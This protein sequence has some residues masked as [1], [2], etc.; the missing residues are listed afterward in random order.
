MTGT[1]YK[2]AKGA[3]VHQ[4]NFIHT[5]A[6]FPALVAGFG[7]GK[8]EGGIMRTLHKKFEHRTMNVGY[9]L[10]TYDL[11]KEI[12]IPRFEEY[13]TASGTPFKINY[14]D[15]VIKIEKAGKI[16][17]RTMMHPERIIGYEHAHAVV[18][19]LDTLQIDKARDVWL[20]ILGRNRQQPKTGKKIKNTCGVVTT[21]EGFRFVYNRWVIGDHGV[22][23]S[24]IGYELIKASTYDNFFLSPDY[25][26]NLLNS[27]PAQLI[28][29]YLNGEFVNLVGDRVYT[30]FDRIANN[31]V[32]TVKKYDILY[33]GMDFNV[34]N[35]SAVVHVLDASGR[36]HAVDEISGALDTPQMVEIIKDRFPKNDFPRIYIFP[37]SSGGNRQT[38]NASTSDIKI[39]ENAGY[40]V[41][42]PTSNPP[43]KDRILAMNMK[44]RNSDGEI[45]YF[46]NV[47]RCPE[48]VRCLEQQIYNKAGAPDKE[49]G[50]D[51]LPDAGGYYLHRRFAV[52]GVYNGRIK[53]KW[54]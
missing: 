18:D 34:G 5:D 26:Q 53:T 10:P 7:S 46:V 20:K 6:T 12:A 42:A 1:Q 23:N 54:N 11:I 49:G 28:E 21:P 29:A 45:G 32:L 13:L 44:F 40:F 17:L 19:E 22:C 39:L 51:H 41:D 48:Y 16:I 27:Y 50:L 30:N 43:V 31:S 47:D 33:I 15:K 52:A 38:N 3:L 24:A 36:P 25:I 2:V 14:S 8:T 37:D 4:M 35:M 9:Y